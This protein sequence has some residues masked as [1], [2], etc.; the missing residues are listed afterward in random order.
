[1]K[2]SENR[3]LHRLIV[4][5]PRGP[6]LPREQRIA[7]SIFERPKALAVRLLVDAKEAANESTTYSTAG[8]EDDYGSVPVSEAP[9]IE[10]LKQS[11]EVRNVTNL[12]AQCIEANVFLEDDAHPFKRGLLR[13]RRN[14]KLPPERRHR[15]FDRA[16]TDSYVFLS[17][18]FMAHHVRV[19]GMKTK[20]LAQPAR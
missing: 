10:A 15:P 6:D 11:F 3:L 16:K 13:T 1:M 14:N 18:Q 7:P 5:F 19:A 20:T 17:L 9:I 2:K 4:K 12:A 8:S